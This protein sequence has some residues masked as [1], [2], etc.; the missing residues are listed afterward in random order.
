MGKIKTLQSSLNG[1]EL[2]P[3]LW[4]RPELPRYQSGL[5]WCENFIPMVLGGAMTRPGLRLVAQALDASGGNALDVY[6]S[7]DDTGV[8]RG[9]CLESNAAQLR[10]F[11][12]YAVADTLANL[13]P[14]GF[15]STQSGQLDDYL[16]LVSQY[17]KPMRVT[18]NS[19]TDWIMEAVPFTSIPLMR[20]PDT[21]AITLAPSATTGAI[22]LVASA[23]FFVAG[24]VGVKFQVNGGLIQVTAVT[25]PT[26]ASATV[27]KTIDPAAGVST[28]TTTFRIQN[29][30]NANCDVSVTATADFN[31][32]TLVPVIPGGLPGGLFITATN[33]STLLNGTNPDPDWLEES[34]SDLRGWPVAVTFY[35]QRMILA[36]SK[37][38]PTTVWGSKSGKPLDF[39]LGTDDDSAFALPIAVADTPIRSLASTDRIYIF[40][41]NREISLDTGNDKALSP[42]NFRIKTRSSQG[43]SYMTPVKSG[44]DLIFPSVSMKRLYSLI[45]HFESDRY[46]A[47]DITIYGE[48]LVH[49]AGGVVQVAIMR[50]PHSMLWC[51]TAAKTIITLT[52]DT[53]QQV[54][55]W[56]RVTTAGAV[57]NLKSVPDDAGNDQMWI[58]V[59]RNGQTNVEAFDWNLQTDSAVIGSDPVGKETWNGLDHLEGMTVVAVADGYAVQNLTVTGGAVTLPFAAKAVEIGL[60]FIGRL[61]DLP[62]GITGSGATISQQT[63]VNE[64]KVLLHETKGCTV[65]G[66]RIPFQKFGGELL[67]KP[68]PAFT[69]WKKVGALG[70]GDNGS[71]GQVEIIRDLP[72]PCTVLAIVKEI[73]V[74][75]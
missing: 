4:G 16:Y 10:A 59:E 13:N 43:A 50:E 56:A 2:S 34:W 11:K 58:T 39:T 69:G 9:F 72:L 48:H 46:V 22:T 32:L 14:L 74:N 36:G 51:R 38:Y 66:E 70:W 71:G 35:E 44:A 67:G 3:K 24:H 17:A 45:Y 15:Q 40:T 73:T 29:T 49:E 55:A 21:D 54:A 18:K 12:G 62:L 20:P 63:S 47:S 41:A 52:Y 31:G 5:Y 6:T 19:D 64:I 61:K 37:T 60:P 68:V 7:L 26:H 33:T 8:Y 42:T 57:T 27:N 1:G 30:T 28:A 25:D 53:E 23:A 65:A 75:G